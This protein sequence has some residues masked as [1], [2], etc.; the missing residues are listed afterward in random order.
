[1]ILRKMNH[2]NELPEN[3]TACPLYPLHCSLPLE[4]EYLKD[5][6]DARRDDSCSLV[7]IRESDIDFFLNHAVK[8]RESSQALSEI[9][10][11]R[12]KEAH[13]AEVVMMNGIIARLENIKRVL[14]SPTGL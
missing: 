13:K 3:C 2:I 7:E 14:L 4:N 8:N 11:Q 6:L 10:N 9:P 12:W 1:M 5:G